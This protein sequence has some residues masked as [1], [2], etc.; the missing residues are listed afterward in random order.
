MISMDVDIDMGER[1]PL[2]KVKDKKVNNLNY[3]D[4]SMPKTNIMFNIDLI[5]ERSPEEETSSED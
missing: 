5:E 4:V 2:A 1:N 3:V